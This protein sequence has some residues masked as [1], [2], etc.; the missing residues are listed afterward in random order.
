MDG[1]FTQRT[2]DTYTSGGGKITIT[3]ITDQ[4][5]QMVRIQFWEQQLLLGIHSF[6][7]VVSAVEVLQDRA[8]ARRNG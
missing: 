8:R 2:E 7:E 1:A 6:D 5:G 3:L 4:E